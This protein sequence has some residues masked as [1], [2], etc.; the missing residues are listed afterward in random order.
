MPTTVKRSGRV[1]RATLTLLLLAGVVTSRAVA[2]EGGA[3][4][5]AGRVTTPGGEPLDNVEVRLVG[6]G[7][8]RV[9]VAGRVIGARNDRQPHA[10]AAALRQRTRAPDR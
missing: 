1:R 9:E 8:V 10:T 6:N 7:P 4:N 5:L 3:P 2:Q